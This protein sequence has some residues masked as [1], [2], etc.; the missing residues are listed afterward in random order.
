MMSQR[1]CRSAVF[2]KIGFIMKGM[3]RGKRYNGSPVDW[4]SYSVS[5]IIIQY[6]ILKTSPSVPAF[7]SFIEKPYGKS[8]GVYP[9]PSWR[10]GTVGPDEADRV[11]IR[12]VVFQTA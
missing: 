11:A 5:I 8:C 9:T 12:S 3:I 1:C 7:C 4:W 2:Q 6:T 10:G